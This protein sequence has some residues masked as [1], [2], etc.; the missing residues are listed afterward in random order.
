MNRQQRE[1]EK[2]KLLY[3]IEQQR[4]DLADHNARWRQVVTSYDRGWLKVVSMRKYLL[5]GS[6]LLVLY[7]VRHPRFIFR[8]S[9]RTI[10]TWGAIR[11]LRRSLFLR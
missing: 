1:Q 5:I 3:V 9:K 2:N 10:G 7:A 6:S 11:L 4:Q 8:W